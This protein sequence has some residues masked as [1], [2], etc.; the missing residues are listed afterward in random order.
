MF[1]IGYDRVWQPPLYFDLE[2]GMIYKQRFIILERAIVIL[3]LAV[4]M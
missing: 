1:V 3:L 4:N 2:I